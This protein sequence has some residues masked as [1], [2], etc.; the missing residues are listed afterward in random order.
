MTYIFVPL[1]ERLYDKLRNSVKFI[2]IILNIVLFIDMI[3]TLIL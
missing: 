2:N 1:A 3:Y